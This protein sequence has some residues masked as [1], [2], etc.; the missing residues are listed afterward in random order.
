[1]VDNEAL[2]Q[3]EDE[4]RLEEQRR[5]FGPRFIEL[6][7][8]VYQTNTK[9]TEVKRQINQLLGSHLIEEKAYAGEPQCAAKANA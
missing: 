5:E 1:V 2:W 6:A 7:R 4:I 8:A 9:R 3:I